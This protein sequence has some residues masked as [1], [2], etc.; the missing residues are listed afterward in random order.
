MQARLRVR[1][2]G[3]AYAAPDASGVPLALCRAAYLAVA[4]P[5]TLYMRI[6]VPLTRPDRAMRVRRSKLGETQ[7]ASAV[8]NARR[9][10]R[11]GAQGVGRVKQVCVVILKGVI[12]APLC[13]ARR[14]RAVTRLRSSR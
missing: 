14:C 2:H 12:L 6:V 4:E 5:R 3:R 9:S 1:P 13:Q 7:R 8:L 11:A 10:V